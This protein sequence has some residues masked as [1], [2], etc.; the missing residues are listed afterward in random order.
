MLNNMMI[1]KFRKYECDVCEMKIEL[2]KDATISEK[3]QILL[4]HYEEHM[5]SPILRKELEK[6]K[7]EQKKLDHFKGELVYVDGK[8]EEPSE[9]D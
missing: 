3:K 2:V 7:T 5:K 9:I 1:K 6:D 8:I 4:N